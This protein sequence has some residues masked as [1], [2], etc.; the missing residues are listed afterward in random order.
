[1]GEETKRQTAIELFNKEKKSITEISKHLGRS[2]QWV[3]KWIQ[4]YDE[5]NA[6]WYKETSRRPKNSSTTISKTTEH[7]IISVRKSLE[8]NPYSQTGAI[9]VQYALRDLGLPIPSIWTINRVI[10]RN[11]LTRKTARY[12]SKGYEYPHHFFDTQ[13]MDI[14]GPCYL[15]EGKRF[16]GISI[17]KELTHTAKTYPK[18]NKGSISAAQSLMNFWKEFGFSDALQMDNELSFRGS[19][20]HPRSLGI[21]LR[22][23][24]SFNVVP[25]FIPIKEPW[26]NGIV[27]RYN[28]TYE[29]HVLK[30]VYCQSMEDL[31]VA[32]DD[33]ASF[34]NANHRYSSQKN[35]TPAQMEQLGGNNLLL[36]PDYELPEYIPLEGG[37]ILFIRF[38]RSDQKLTILGSSF[39]VHKDLIYSYITAELIIHRHTLVIIRDQKIYHVYHFPMPVD[40]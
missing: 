25:V 35:R 33:F 14:I 32:S 39:K 4:R 2:R 6:D 7:S 34:H 8:E 28:Q 3:Y 37:I 36:D 27:E 16:F 13:Q 31:C 24:L 23:A 38:I 29:R 21:V 30:S 26:R 5:G 1:M 10:K 12:V 15:G 19:N 17:I 9:S 18:P 40:W 11:G 22:L 20:R